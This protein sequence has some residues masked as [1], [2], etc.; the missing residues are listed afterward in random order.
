MFARRPM[1]SVFAILDY[2][3]RGVFFLFLKFIASRAISESV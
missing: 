1:F 2:I 3:F